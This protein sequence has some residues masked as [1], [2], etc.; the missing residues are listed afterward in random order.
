MRPLRLLTLL[1]IAASL[2]GVAAQGASAQSDEET[3]TAQIDIPT[4]LRVEVD[5]TMIDF[6]TPDAEDFQQG[7]VE[8][9]QNNHVE[10]WG[11]VPHDLQIQAQAEF[12]SV[13]GAS[14]DPEKPAADLEW[15]PAGEESWQGLSTAAEN[16]VSDVGPGGFAGPN[17]QEISYRMLLDFEDDLP[18]DY[19]LTFTY[20]VVPN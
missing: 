8:A 17:G 4:V 2:F 20:V 15:S 18:G 13:S 9:T 6:G 12:F 10:H 14:E 3:V 5:E 7:Y 1:L 11:N 19:E 16:I